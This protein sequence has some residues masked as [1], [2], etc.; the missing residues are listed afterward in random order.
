MI[1]QKATFCRSLRQ[2]PFLS[3]HFSW[4]WDDG[5]RFADSSVLEGTFA[6][7]LD[8]IFIGLTTSVSQGHLDAGASGHVSGREVILVR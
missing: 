2:N 3:A 6:I 4:H 7:I 8:H 1:A 5:R